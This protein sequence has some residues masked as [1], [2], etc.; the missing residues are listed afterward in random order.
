MA[1]FDKGI[2]TSFNVERYANNCQVPRKEIKVLCPRGSFNNS[3]ELQMPKIS[4]IKT[5]ERSNQNS[6]IFFDQNSIDVNLN[7]SNLKK[8]KRDNPTGLNSS[9]KMT[10]RSSHNKENQSSV[11]SINVTLSKA[12]GLGQQKSRNSIGFKSTKFIKNPL[13]V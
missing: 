6:T 12:K 4:V 11:K 8:S 13:D 10:Q 1:S 2:R 7:R 9:K 3:R 5:M